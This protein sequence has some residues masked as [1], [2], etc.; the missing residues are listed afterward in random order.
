MTTTLTQKQ[1]KALKKEI[2]ETSASEVGFYNSLFENVNPYTMLEAIDE[3]VQS[4]FYLSMKESDKFN[5][6]ATNIVK[7]SSYQEFKELAPHFFGFSSYGVLNKE[8]LLNTV[9]EDD[10]TNRGGVSFVGETLADFLYEV[11]EEEY[12]H[13][14]FSDE[15]LENVNAM[16][17]E[18]GIRPLAL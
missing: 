10:D 6:L 1:Y 15:W 9:L 8:K 2:V 13:Y 16:L 17:V 4:D 18:C 5:F 3:A 12:I 7:H 14:T 11:G